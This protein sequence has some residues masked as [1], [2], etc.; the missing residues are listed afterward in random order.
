MKNR[1]L[2]WPILLVLVGMAL[3]LWI[4]NRRPALSQNSFDGRRA[5]RDV[6]Y[7]LNLG[8]RIPGSDAHRLVI[9]WIVA[10]LRKN[11]WQTEIQSGMIADHSFQNIVAKR[12]S[13]SQPV[14]FGAHFDTRIMADQD[15]DPS[16]RALP[17]PGANDGASG[18]AVLLEM[19]RVLPRDLSGETWLVFFDIEDQGDL[20]GWDWILGSRAF[21]QALS[22]TPQAVVVIDMIGDAE[23]NIYKERTSTPLLAHQIWQAAAEAGYARQWI[24]QVKFSMIDDHTPFLQRGFP[25]VDVID[26]DY[27]YWHTTADT[28][29]KV[30]AESLEAVGKSLIL[31]LQSK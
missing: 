19:A 28:A 26:F 13:G 20:P 12:G 3:L 22:V 17:V 4:V 6:A 30:S 1:R 9:E 23:L 25:A 8:P 18:V 16:K 27:P 5:W 2:L 21:A 14:L 10:E 11:G 24:D 15:P 7:Q 31:W 29:D